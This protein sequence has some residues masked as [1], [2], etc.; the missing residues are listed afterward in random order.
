[1]IDL[2][3]ETASDRNLAVG[4]IAVAVIP[5]KCWFIPNDK[6]FEISEPMSYPCAVENSQ[7][8]PWHRLTFLT[9]CGS[10]DHAELDPYRGCSVAASDRRLLP[11]VMVIFDVLSRHSA[12]GNSLGMVRE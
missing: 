3:G 1:M 4:E 9:Y 2:L 11:L 7:N 12:A 10:S 5:S 6:S 8:Q